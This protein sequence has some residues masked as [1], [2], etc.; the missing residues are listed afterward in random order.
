MNDYKTKP[1][2]ERQKFVRL[3]NEGEVKYVM[4]L[5]ENLKD[6]MAHNPDYWQDKTTLCLEVAIKLLQRKEDTIDNFRTAKDILE[7]FNILRPNVFEAHYYL[8]ICYGYLGQDDDRDNLYR[9]IPEWSMGDWS[10]ALD[11]IKANRRREGG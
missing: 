3:L 10:H 5:L 2:T 8:A 1:M 9:E 6:K 7:K 11:C 4:N